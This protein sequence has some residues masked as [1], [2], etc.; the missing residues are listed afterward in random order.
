[1]L[2]P[3][4]CEP[5]VNRSAKWQRA[6]GHVTL[7]TE[8]SSSHGI[9]GI[10]GFTR[11]T[12]PL[13][14]LMNKKKLKI[15]WPLIS[16]K[17]VTGKTSNSRRNTMICSEAGPMKQCGRVFPDI[18]EKCAM[19]IH[20]EFQELMTL[21]RSAFSLHFQQTVQSGLSTST[22]SVELEKNTL[23]T[24]LSALQLHAW[25]KVVP[26]VD[27]AGARTEEMKVIA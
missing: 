1:M 19:L 26:N 3:C 7:R 20:Q 9:V 10:K 2:S 13:T 17:V 18:T 24:I 25:M 12:R 21:S 11:F 27:V 4:Q 6:I 8:I 14:C 16:S 15:S 23:Y 5:R 22:A